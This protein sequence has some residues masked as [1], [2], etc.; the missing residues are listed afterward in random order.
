MS[1]EGTREEV[2]KGSGVELGERAER[3]KK[4][5]G[6]DVLSREFRGDRSGMRKRGGERKLVEEMAGT[7]GG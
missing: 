4:H 6:F 1:G 5:R 7:E 2:N 3:E